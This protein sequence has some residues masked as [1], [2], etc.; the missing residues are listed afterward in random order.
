MQFQNLDLGFYI[1]HDSD[2]LV[3]LSFEQLLSF[4]FWC[5]QANKTKEL[6]LE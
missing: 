3:F 6:E 2:T 4:F 5:S 1:E